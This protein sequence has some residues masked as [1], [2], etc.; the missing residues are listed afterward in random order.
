MKRYNFISV[1]LLSYITCGLYFLHVISVISINNN[2]IA[3]KVKK[4]TI[5]HIVAMVLIMVISAIVLGVLGVIME[6]E[7]FTTLAFS[8]PAIIFIVWHYLFCK[9]QCEILEAYNQKSV[10]IN[11]P[12]L[13]MLTFFVPIYGFYV[14]CKNYNLGVNASEGIM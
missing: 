3:Q 9:Q 12:I 11:N 2:F 4:K 8:V 6:A 13:I 7:I 1:F 5:M 10:P 14:L